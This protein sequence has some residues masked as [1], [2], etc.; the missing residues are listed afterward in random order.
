M[1]KIYHQSCN[2]SRNGITLWEIYP[3]YN[4]FNGRWR[5]SSSLKWARQPPPTGPM[6]DKFQLPL[7]TT[8]Y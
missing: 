7:A 8:L 4:R 1:Q 3:T 5:A 6:W 2:D